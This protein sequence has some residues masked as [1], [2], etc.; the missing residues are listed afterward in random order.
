[1]RRKKKKEDDEEVREKEPT[2]TCNVKHTN[3]VGRG[4]KREALVDSG[5]HMVKKAAVDCLGQGVACVVCL[6]HL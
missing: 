3:E 1:M 6:L 5:D 4:I 2:E